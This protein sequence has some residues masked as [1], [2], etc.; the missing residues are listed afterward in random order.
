VIISW[1]KSTA[2]A[3]AI[4]SALLFL[5]F[6]GSAHA[7][8]GDLDLTWGTSGTSALSPTPPGWTTVPYTVVRAPSG[9]IL[10]GVAIEEHGGVIALT[11]TGA[12]DRSWGNNGINRNPS[13]AGF[14][15]S[16]VTAIGFDSRGRI[17]ATGV[18]DDLID[19]HGSIFLERLTA[20]G[21]TDATFN[22][23][24][25]VVVTTSSWP[26]LS[27]IAIAPDDSVFV[28]SVEVSH[29]LSTGVLDPVWGVGG[30]CAIQHPLGTTLQ[31]SALAID[32]NGKLLVANDAEVTRRN[33][34]CA[35]DTTFGT[36]GYAPLPTMS[37]GVAV[38]RV[39]VTP[40]AV[41]VGGGNSTGPWVASYNHS[42]T[43]TAA[44][45]A[46]GLAQVPSSSLPDEE[47]VGGLVIDASG[48]ILVG[49]VTNDS[50]RQSSSHFFVA[51]VTTLGLVDSSFGV[52][53]VAMLTVPAPYL[54]SASTFVPPAMT[55]DSSGGLIFM[56]LAT[57]ST[58]SG[59]DYWMLSQ[60]ATY[61]SDSSPTALAS[62]GLS[63]AVLFGAFGGAAI[64]LLAGLVLTS[65]RR[66]EL[67]HDSN[68]D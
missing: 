57:S 2:L 25:P 31:P 4:G 45:G 9:R 18:I 22:G 15:A 42:G 19:A 39:L 11:S 14:G 41:I 13:V 34:S 7:A 67:R 26:A 51:R 6:P 47:L 54:L 64:L 55:Q 30:V 1:H 44:F 53:G 17:L 60:R 32:T 43:P 58:G 5:A 28:G 20:N 48:N 8:T 62:T 33:Y 52:S 12:I 56:T 66:K 46:G 27:H 49:G 40:S 24:S 65:L 37:F 68:P 38:T 50:R 10:S 59:I 3:A 63:D 36:V 16:R 23:G 21:L 61:P 35:A 29:V